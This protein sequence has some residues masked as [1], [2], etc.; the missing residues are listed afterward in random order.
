MSLTFDTYITIY[1]K[2]DFNSI[3]IDCFLKKLDMQDKESL[4]SS[5][6]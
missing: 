4:T 1:F 3:N 6:V 5:P 2:Y